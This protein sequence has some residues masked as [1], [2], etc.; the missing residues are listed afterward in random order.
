MSKKLKSQSKKTRVLR[1][2]ETQNR[3]KSSRSKSR[4]NMSRLKW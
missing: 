2:V 3:T 1:R 4:Q